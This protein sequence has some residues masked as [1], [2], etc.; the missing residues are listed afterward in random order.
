[1]GKEFVL[2]MNKGLL[3]NGSKTIP[4]KTFKYLINGFLCD[5]FDYPNA[6]ISFNKNKKR[7]H[8]Y[9]TIIHLKLKTSL[10]VKGHQILIVMR[11]MNSILIAKK[12]EKIL[13]I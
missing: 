6:L 13:M 2:D 8:E 1:M 5:Y 12:L 11:M 7:N 4:I 10:D 3:F 9:A